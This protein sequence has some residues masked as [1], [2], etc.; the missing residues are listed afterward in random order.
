MEVAA[1]REITALG[2]CERDDGDGL[3]EIGFVF[4]QNKER[5]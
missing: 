3:C 4:E 1:E 5:N 2:W